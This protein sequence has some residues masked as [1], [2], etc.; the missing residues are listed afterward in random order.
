VS[1]ARAQ[2][3]AQRAEAARLA[4]ERR[5]ADADRAAAVRARQQRRALRWRQ[6]RLWRH[7]AGYSRR[8]EA[9]GA[10]AA[11]VLVLCVATYVIT[12]SATDVLVLGLVLLVGAP[13]LALI[14]F[15]RRRS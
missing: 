8:R 5:R 10:L 1:K 4:A 9:V 13:V 11:A 2:A 12:R 15:D 3:R 7:G 14:F 6:L